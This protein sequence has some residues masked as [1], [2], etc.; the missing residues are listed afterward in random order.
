MTPTAAS[1]ADEIAVEIAAVNAAVQ[2]WFNG[3]DEAGFL[4]RLMGHFSDDCSVVLPDG[5]QL[6]RTSLRDIFAARAGQRPQLVIEITEIALLA[7]WD[8]G[9]VATYVER[10]DDRVGNRNARRST[11]LFTR[12]AEGAPRWRRLHET[13]FRE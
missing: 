5:T 9:A 8:A 10:Q 11:V 3:T 1:C 4:D 7:E 6:D 12:D 13:F 2:T